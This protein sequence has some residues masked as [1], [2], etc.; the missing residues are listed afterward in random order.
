MANGRAGSCFYGPLFPSSSTTSLCREI[1]GPYQ[2]LE[3]SLHKV[4]LLERIAVF[5]AFLHQVPFWRM[6]ALRTMGCLVSMPLERKQSLFKALKGLAKLS[7]R[8]LDLKILQTVGLC[9]VIGLTSVTLLH[10]IGSVTS[11]SM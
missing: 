5:V 7:S 4:F 2:R 11:C 10:T 8:N 9:V 1:E 6:P 3:A